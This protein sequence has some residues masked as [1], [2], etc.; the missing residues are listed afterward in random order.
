[1]TTGESRCSSTYRRGVTG[2]C[3]A[4]YHGRVPYIDL[5]GHQ[6]W[7]TV[8]D[9]DKAETVVLLHG[10]LSNG[11]AM[12]E[13]IGPPLRRTYRLTA[14]D[15]R[16]HGRTADTD[17]PFHYATMADETIAFLEHIGGPA[18]LVGW[19]DGGIIGLIVALR[20][21]DLVGRLVLIGANYHYDGV[22]HAELAP[23]SPMIAMIATSYAERSPDGT[24][25][26]GEV[27]RKSM[28]LFATEPT[29]TTADIAAVSVPVLVLVGD[30]D[31][32]ELAHT[33]SLY[34]S[35]PG[36]QLAVVPG[37]SHALPAEQPAETARL[38]EQFLK[39]ALPPQTWMPSRRA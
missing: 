39:A 19:S 31:L 9:G 29:M 13:T 8:D 4:T 15:R 6:T 37:T 2:F 21:P 24:D 10:G 7:I 23:D 16:G 28:T 20:R 33:C 30:D 14:F 36:A 18:H 5:L 3:G 32:I 22:R 38:V 26:F 25:H 11:D 1:M 35:I 34:E 12:L 27:V 17:E